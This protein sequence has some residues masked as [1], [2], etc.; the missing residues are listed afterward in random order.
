[1]SPLSIEFSVRK[2]RLY[3]PSSSPSWSL[4]TFF[5]LSTIS[6]DI[7][8]RVNR[9]F[10]SCNA[11]KDSE[12]LT[13]WSI[14]KPL[15][16]CKS[17]FVSTAFPYIPYKLITPTISLFSIMV[18]APPSMIIMAVPGFNR[19]EISRIILICSTNNVSFTFSDP[20]ILAT[21]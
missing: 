2:L 3:I 18:S 12:K 4:M 6:L 19:M 5:I 7:T 9:L 17:S 11:P 8:R 14:I 10:R 21:S 13:S 16:A 15:S 1:M 20:I